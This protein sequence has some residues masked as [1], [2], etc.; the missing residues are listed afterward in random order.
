M[1]SGCNLMVV[2]F[3]GIDDSGHSYGDL[4][5]QTLERIRTTDGYVKDLVSR[6]SGKVIITAD[7]GMHST[8][9]GGSHGEFRYEDMI[10]PYIIC[11]GDGEK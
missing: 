7:H 11:E 9:E 2:H 1:D 8:L 6:W 5:A 10:V 4:S 3:H